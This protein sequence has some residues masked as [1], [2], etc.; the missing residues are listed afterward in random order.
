VLLLKSCISISNF[1]WAYEYITKLQHSF[2]DFI[3][4]VSQHGQGRYLRSQHVGKLEPEVSFKQ[5]RKGNQWFEMSQKLT[6]IVVSDIKY[7]PKFK[8]ILCQSELCFINEHY[9]PTMFNILKPSKIANQTLTY[10]DFPNNGTTSPHPFQWEPEMITQEWIHD[11]KEGYNRTYNGHREYNNC[12]LFARKFGPQ[13]V[14]S[15][16]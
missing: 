9:L 7:Y 16:F 12:H 3:D 5:W 10:F 2:I 15:S 13:I 1:S 14:E 6:M 4:D 11:L 8:N